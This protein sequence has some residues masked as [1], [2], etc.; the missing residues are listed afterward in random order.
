MVNKA[1]KEPSNVYK[2]LRKRPESKV[3][4]GRGQED[5][6]ERRIRVDDKAGRNTVTSFLQ[7]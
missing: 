3:C 5:K 1:I 6:S 4:G 7:E 2:W